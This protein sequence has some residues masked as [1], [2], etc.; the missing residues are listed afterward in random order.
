[1]ENDPAENDGLS[2]ASKRPIIAEAQGE[3]RE[4]KEVHWT[5]NPRRKSDKLLE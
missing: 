2:A 5:E 3:S 1:M 4:F